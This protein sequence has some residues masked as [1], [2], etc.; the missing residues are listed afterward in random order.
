M[1]T[2]H[3]F[4]IIAVLTLFGHYAINAQGEASRL[5]QLIELSDKARAIESETIR[6]LIHSNQR[7][8]EQ[9]ASEK[10]AAYVSGVVTALQKPDHYSAIWHSGYDRGTEVQKFA[11]S[12]DQ[13]GDL[14]KV[15]K[16]TLPTK[17]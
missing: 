2:I 14:P 13:A 4:A 10:N 5:K 8:A 12:I 11:Q 9:N 17:K 6:D 16:V 3:Y 7:L 15:T 1:K